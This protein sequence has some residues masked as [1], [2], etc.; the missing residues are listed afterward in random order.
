MRYMAIHR[1]LLYTGPSYS[2][3]ECGQ[4]KKG[5]VVTA[6]HAK[7][8]ADGRWLRTRRGWACEVLESGSVVMIAEERRNYLLMVTARH[9]LFLKQLLLIG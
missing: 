4:L 8:T 1:T 7:V 5:G 3:Q 9:V 6:T 2:E